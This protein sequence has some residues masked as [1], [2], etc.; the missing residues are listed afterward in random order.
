MKLLR[1]TVAPPT[2]PEAVSAH[3]FALAREKE[4]QSN[5]DRSLML[6]SS[7]AEIEGWIGAAYFGADRRSVAVLELADVAEA[8]ALV[9]T[10]PDSE[11]VVLVSVE[12]WDDSAAAFVSTPG[13]TRRPEN[14]LR[15][16]APGTYR[17]T[18]TV[19]APDVLPPEVTEA[20]ARCWAFRENRRPGD[21]DVGEVPVNLA[22]A[23]MR[24]GAAECIR[25]LKRATI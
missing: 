23:V 18:A 20:V 12:R 15:L 13:Y 2:I 7:A 1:G 6:V 11:A 17:L 14:R 9:P 3:A 4:L 19:N 25:H 24:S 8:V 21:L 22:G 16:H 10:L 5:A